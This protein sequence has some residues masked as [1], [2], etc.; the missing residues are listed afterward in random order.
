MAVKLHTCSLTW[1]KLGMHPCHVVRKALD[2]AG[3]EY[4]Q[5]TGPL[6]RGKRTDL[7]QLSG[8]KLYPVIEFEDGRVYRD[9][10]KAMAARIRDGK[11]FEGR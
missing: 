7:V 3:V 1:F 2:E 5:V 9:E 6:A 4:K 11:L 8:Q 10:S